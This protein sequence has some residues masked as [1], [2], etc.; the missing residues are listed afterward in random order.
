MSDT[1]YQLVDATTSTV[2]EGPLAYT[3]SGTNIFPTAG[4]YDPG[5]LVSLSGEVK[6]GDSFDLIYNTNG[7]GDSRNG[8]LM[9]DLL[10]KSTIGW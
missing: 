4:G 7:S 1:T 5:Y 9:A 3:S 2:I 10:K 8:K 6:A